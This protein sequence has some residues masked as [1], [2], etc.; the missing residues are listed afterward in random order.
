MS[1]TVINFIVF[2]MC[3][4]CSSKQKTLTL[5]LGSPINNLEKSN[6]WILIPNND[7]VESHNIMVDGIN[8]TIGVRDGIIVYICTSDG[9]FTINNY[10]IGT[11]IPED[12]FD[13]ELG[14]TPGWGYYL[15][16]GSGWYAC[17][18]FTKKTAEKSPIQFFFKYDFT[19][20][21]K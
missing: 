9:K 15:E 10:Q 16:I 19:F 6:S 13:R 14:Y 20:K 7:L 18:D 5:A 2:V 12:L 21:T 3:L 1:R 8:F 17:F 4:S 11:P